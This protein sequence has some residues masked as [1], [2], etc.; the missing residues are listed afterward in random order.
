MRSKQKF[1]IESAEMSIIQ[2]WISLFWTSPPAV[3]VAHCIAA[4]GERKKKCFWFISQEQRGCGSRCVGRAKD[5][6]TLPWCQ[7]TWDKND[8]SLIQFWLALDI[9][10]SSIGKDHP[11]PTMAQNCSGTVIVRQFKRKTEH[12]QNL[13][14]IDS[15]LREH[16]PTRSL[17]CSNMSLLLL[18]L[19]NYFINRGK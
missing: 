2:S 10:Q 13:T 8:E 4:R 18:S 11:E 6:V 15:S 12:Q 1:L 7:N 16:H 19:G 5:A 17:V 14:I 3:S 9:Q